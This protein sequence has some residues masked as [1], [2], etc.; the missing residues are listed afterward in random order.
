VSGRAFAGQPVQA[1]SI[2]SADVEIHD[3]PLVGLGG[4]FWHTPYPIGQNG[5]WLIRV[6]TIFP[7]VLDSDQFSIGR[8]YLAFRLG[9]SAGGGVGVELRIPAATATALGTAAL[10]SPDGDGF[11][12]VRVAHPSGSDPLVELTWDLTPRQGPSLLGAVAKV[13]L[14]II[15]ARRP[16]RLLVDDIRLGARRPP[17]FHRPLWGWADLHC[18]PMSQAGFGGLLDGHMHGP[19]EDLG[20]CLPAHG[21]HHNNLL[22]PVALDLG[23]GKSND[24]SLATTGWTEGT[25]GPEDELAFRAWPSFS[26]LIHIKTHQAWI[27]RAY[28]GGQRLMAAL[29]VHNEMLATLTNLATLGYRAQTDRDTVEPQ[30]QMM[31]EFVAHN[32]AWCGLAANPAE[33]RA[34]IESNRMAFVLGLET[35]SVNGWIRF[36]NFPQDDT[37]ASRTAIHDTIH[38]YF[39]YLRGLGIVQINLVHLSN[40][41]FGGMAVYDFMFVVNSLYHTG[42]LPDTKPWSG[43]NPD[44]LVARQVTVGSKLWSMIKGLA[45]PAGITVPSLPAGSFGIGDRNTVGLTV[46]GEVA[47]L[48][49]MRLGMVIDTDHMS[50]LGE[51]TAFRIATTTVA[52]VDYPLVSAHN[53]P[54]ILAPRPLDVTDPPRHGFRRASA[55][56]PSEAMKSETQLDHIKTTGG[57]FG[58][59]I[60]GADTREAPGT[61]VGNDLPGTSRT[62]AQGYQYILGRLERPAGFGTDWN[63]LLAGPGPRF[64]PLAGSGILGELAE[65]DATWQ[66]SVRAERWQGATA[67]GNGVRYDSPLREWRSFRFDDPE[68]FTGTGALE[69]VGQHAW[70]ALVLIDS[71]ADLTSAEVAAALIPAGATTAPTLDI[72]RGLSGMAGTAPNPAAAGV[73]LARAAFIAAN[74]A[75][76][77][78]ADPAAV[79]DLASGIATVLGLWAAMHAST[80]PPMRRDTVG[81]MRDFDYN[82]DGLAHYGLLPDML[83]DLR[84]VGL[85][86]GAMSALFGSAEQYVGVWERSVAVG[87]R[88]P[89]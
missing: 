11:V 74:P 35:D 46:A 54:R 43:A 59:G 72:A 70:Q 45:A 19:V 13:R 34:L 63:A 88:I 80:A 78:P 67:Q 89:H 8:R 76:A 71:G 37:P 79:T 22:K 75:S 86:A 83:Q 73:D 47:L 85:S 29:V 87:A 51:A 58:V 57:M 31:R 7:G 5:S 62:F 20:N 84:N 10:D 55:A 18:H 15:R 48:E 36:D 14:R 52:G 42:S 9:G 53:A 12:A 1:A 30:V 64:G 26:D 4:D 81:P 77:T 82:L 39:A 49:A 24:G 6:V 32:G 2:G 66:A 69:G 23:A 40:N 25:P 28:D 50:E 56:W 61:T 33:A 44:E 68:L 27:R 16:Q 17:R 65:G 41:A 3:R 38:D 60:A 21:H